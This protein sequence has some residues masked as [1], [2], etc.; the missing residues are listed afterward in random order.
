MLRQDPLSPSGGGGGGDGTEIHP[1]GSGVV[2]T[3][4]IINFFIDIYML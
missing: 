4:S 2:K 3:V 1:P